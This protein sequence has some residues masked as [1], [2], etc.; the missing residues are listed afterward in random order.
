[1]NK[2]ALETLEYYFII[3]ELKNYAVSNLGKKLVDK[4]HPISD[5]DVINKQQI[6][7]DEV[8]AIVDKSY[9]IPI[10]NLVG[11]EN[12][13]DKLGKGMAL[14]PEELVSVVGML[15]STNKI[16]KFMEDKVSLAPM[17]S[18]Y[19]YSMYELKDV[20]EEIN[21][22]IINNRIDDKASPQLNTIRKQIYIA[23]ARIKQKL[24]S[25]LKSSAYKPYLQEQFVSIRHGRSVIAVKSQ[26]K[27]M[28]DGAVIDSSSTGSTV[29][30]EPTSV[31]KAQNDLDMLKA[32][33]EKEEYQILMYLTT[34]V[35]TYKKEIDINIETMAYYDFIFAK[36]KLSKSMNGTRPLININNYTKLV[37]ARHPRLGNSAVPLDFKIGKG[38][39]SLV[40]TGP[41]TGGKTVALKTVGLLTL[42][43]QSGLHIPAGNGSE[44]A[45]YSEILVDIGDKQS[46]EQ[47][48]STF[49]GHI[50]NIIEILK[51]TNKFIMVILDELGAG[52][53][54]QEG[55]G[56]AVAILEEIYNKGATTLATSHYS[57]VKEFA[58]NTEGFI[59]GKMVFN[60]QTLSPEYKLVIG[61]AGES[62]AFNIALRLGMDKKIVEKAYYHTYSEHKEFDIT[63][64]ED[65][66]KNESLKMNKYQKAKKQ[67]IRTEGKIAKPIENE[68]NIGDMVKIPS[69]NQ[70]GIVYAL[71]NK[72]GEIGVMIQKKK[73][74]MP[75]KRVQL[76]IE[77]KELYPDADKYDFDIIFETVEN[78]KKKNTMGRKHV[79]GLEII[80][81][82][83]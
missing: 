5:I 16:I 62:N 45:V 29:F 60:V 74:M 43:A 56:L 23:E 42:M 48:L 22:A 25:V 70:K 79:E 24:E 10:Q 57:N 26:Y 44:I 65:K 21:N 72:K 12:I 71:E 20:I 8:R 11:I 58:K 30:I 68:Y 38:Y 34:L 69:M 32:D 31:R 7:L 67:R 2:N 51:V 47:S 33:E 64:L 81:E 73:V 1:M 49:S 66:E 53:D 77:A 18:Q 75:K 61:E 6:E 76:F 13:I 80:Y 41:N 9:S 4:V 52:T 59:N 55:D 39:R 46:I 40:I 17:V 19:A 15:E 28:I 3:D 54:P 82:K 14:N 50:K 78:R 37:K 36:G 83:E 63:K 27:H 35:E